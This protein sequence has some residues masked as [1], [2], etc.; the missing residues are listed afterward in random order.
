MVFCILQ[1][2]TKAVYSVTLFTS[3]TRAI[4][5][6]G[7]IAEAHHVAILYCA[8]SHP[9]CTG[10]LFLAEYSSRDEYPAQLIPSGAGS[11]HAHTGRR[12]FP[13]PEQ[14]RE[15]RHL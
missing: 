11:A 9:G 7:C 12:Y 8:C 10:N 1:F 14:K 6:Q 5:I 15:A 3:P 13:R 2:S 4:V